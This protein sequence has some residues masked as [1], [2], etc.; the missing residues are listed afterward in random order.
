[1]YRIPFNQMK[2]PSR[3]SISSVR[4]LFVNRLGTACSRVCSRSPP[5]L[6][7]RPTVQTAAASSSDKYS[8]AGR[9]QV[10]PLLQAGPVSPPQPRHLLPGTVSHRCLT[11]HWKGKSAGPVSKP[12]LTDIPVAQ[13]VEQGAHNTKVMGS[14]PR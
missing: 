7:R 1:M 11:A 10:S 5:R 13:L 4:T 8:S 9:G 3:D 6:S 12:S 14:I 2:T